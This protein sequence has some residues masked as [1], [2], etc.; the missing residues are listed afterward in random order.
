MDPDHSDGASGAFF[1]DAEGRDHALDMRNLD[2]LPKTGPEQLIWF[3]IDRSDTA[4]IARVG[5]MLALSPETI[6]AMGS[7]DA[8]PRLASYEKYFHFSLT[9]ADVQE[10]PVINF[11]VCE[12]W[13]LTVR[14]GEVPY[15]TAYRE[16]DRGE[17]LIG[18]LSPLMLAGSLIDWHFEGYQ[19]AVATMQRDL[20]RLDSAI[21]GRRRARPPLS[22]LARMRLNVARLRRRLDGHRP[23]VHALLRPDFPRVSEEKQGEYFSVLENHF[24][25]AADN[26]ERMR[27]S[28][29]G[30]FD[31]YATRT[32]QETN[33]LVRLLT[34][35][36]V[37]T[38]LAAAIAGIFGMNFEVP[39]FKWGEVGFAITLVMMVGVALALFIIAWRRGWLSP[40]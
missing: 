15:F 34:L 25:G 3:D 11:A 17:S 38:G 31:L 27:E 19:E 20:D 16:R 29:I 2:K 18:R 5:E 32:A 23:L 30:S 21:L 13:L 1:Y 4:A 7:G 14:D 40:T 26:V 9:R 35:V 22:D 28:V 12:R 8:V 10:K 33:D 6:E 39:F 24:L 36:T 37:A